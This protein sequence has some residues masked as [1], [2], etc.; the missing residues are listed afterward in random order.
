LNSTT[1]KDQQQQYNTQKVI[2]QLFFYQITAVIRT[3]TMFRK[4]TIIALILPTLLVAAQT[5]T[6]D[7]AFTF[8]IINTGKTV[9]CAWLTLHN[10][11]IR[12]PKYCDTDPSIKEACC[13]S[14]NSFIPCEDTSGFTFKLDFN[15]NT[16]GCNWFL[17]SNHASTRTSTYCVE[18]GS[19]YDVDIADGCINSCGL[20][21]GGNGGNSAPTISPPARRKP[22]VLLIMADDF[23][24]GDVPAYWNSSI[25]DMPNLNRLGAK[26]VTFKDV[27]ST[28]LCAP[29][30]YMLL[31]G[32]YAHRGVHKQGTWD[33]TQNSNQFRGKQ[34][35]IAKVLKDGANYHTYMAGKWHLGAKVPPN[36]SYNSTHLL[37]HPMH[38][39]SQALIDGPPDIGFDSSFITT[40][41]IQD[42]PYS[43][44]KD[45]YLTTEQEDVVY[46]DTYSE[47]DMPH[48]RSVIGKHG[49]EG[50][51]DW[52]STAYNMILVNET[53]A[54]VD[55]H[56]HD[57]PE[58]PFF[59]YVA[60]GGVHIPH[61][62]PGKS[63][64]WHHVIILL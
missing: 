41:G 56:L 20:C 1:N 12:I 48:G 25:V 47:H 35:S 9:D 40:G 23:G 8:D 64:H 14:C 3:S 46:W 45:G 50:S 62:P 31:S 37:T 6:D 10:P 29:S 63:L 22:N 33:I 59:A 58:D 61:S 19:L 53:I 26:G 44:F 17:K 38:D 4:A 57:K 49:G 24:T 60:L 18:S 52:D 51:N 27:H 13:I 32:L 30:R 42:S 34:K 7:D 21:T 11:D 2:V 16:V 5:C 28:P 54:F 55:N 36:G 43:F 39:W 15:G